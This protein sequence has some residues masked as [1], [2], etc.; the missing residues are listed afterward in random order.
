MSSR[1]PRAILT[2]AAQFRLLW[3]DRVAFLHLR[4]PAAA[5]GQHQDSEG[6]QRQSAPQVGID[7][8]TLCV[9]IHAI[10]RGE[11]ERG[12]NG[13]C[14]RE[15]HAHRDARV[16]MDDGMNGWGD[17]RFDC[18]IFL[19]HGSPSHRN[20]KFTAMAASRITAAAM[21]SGR[22]HHAAIPGAGPRTSPASSAGSRGLVHTLTTPVTSRHTMKA[23]AA[24]PKPRAISLAG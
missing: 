9:H 4:L 5:E 8:E 24:V 3:R 16:D 10:A 13:S 12:E 17:C 15:E 23:R 7:P 11:A 19:R 18:K 1:C 22:F 2:R 21:V 14:Q 6:E 20:I